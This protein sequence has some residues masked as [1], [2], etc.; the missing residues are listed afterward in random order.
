VSEDPDKFLGQRPATLLLPVERSGKAQTLLILVVGIIPTGLGSGFVVAALLNW[1]LSRLS[2][3]HR[4]R[5][6]GAWYD[7]FFLC[8]FAS[9]LVIL[10][11]AA[12][13]GGWPAAFM[14]MSVVC[15][16]SAIGCMSWGLLTRPV[17]SDKL[18][19]L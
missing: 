4:A 7:T 19:P 9:P 11:M 17:P 12:A 14:A 15:A 10:A 1:T 8:Q 6:V 3:Q 5:G 18:A 13:V 2:L 16:V